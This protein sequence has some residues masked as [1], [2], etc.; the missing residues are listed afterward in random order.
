MT[1]AAEVTTTLF[2]VD[3]DPEDLIFFKTATEAIG[4]DVTLFSLG[5][6]MIRAMQNPPPA[7]SIV[8]LDLNMPLRSGYDLLK[9]LKSSFA[10]CNIPI[11]ILSTACDRA[12]IQKCR[13]L[14][15]S[16]Y[17]TKPPSLKLLKKVLE[18]V[19]KIDWTNFNTNDQNFV[20]HAD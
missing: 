15:A 19:V 20:F 17:V 18:G 11:V 5:D 3:D 13:D 2:Y 9:E 4:E 14:G 6:E 1:C 16:L 8:F 10:F 12:T 7:P